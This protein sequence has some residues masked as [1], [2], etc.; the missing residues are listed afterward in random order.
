MSP[1]H[2]LSETDSVTNTVNSPNFY[3]MKGSLKDAIQEIVGAILL[4]TFRLR[5]MY[6]GKVSSYHDVQEA[7]FTRTSILPCVIQ[8]VK[9]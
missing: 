1:L 6:Q 9:Q 3:Y 2:K 5:M 7:H 4:L 8:M